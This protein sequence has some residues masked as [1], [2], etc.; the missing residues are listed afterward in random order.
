MARE[1]TFGEHLRNSYAGLLTQDVIEG[2]T[3][4]LT[5]LGLEIEPDV[6]TD[7]P[8]FLDR[9]L[10]TFD[11]VYLGLDDLSCGPWQLEEDGRDK[12]RV[13][14][15]TQKTGRQGVFAG[16]LPYM[17]T[18]SPV[19]QAAEGRFAANSIDRYLQK[20]SL[21]AGREK[22]GPL[23]TRLFTSMTDVVSL[24]VVEAVDPLH[25]YTGEEALQEA[26]R[27]LQCQCLECVK[28]CVYLERFGA[29]PKKYAR[30][31]YNNESIVMGPRQANKL[32]NSCSLCGL[33]QM[34]CPEGFAMQ[35]LCLQ[36]RQG[37][38]MRGKMPPSAHE[39]AL[40]DMAFSQGEQFALARH[41]PGLMESRQA[42]FPGCQLC[43]SA[44]D[45]IPLVYEHLRASLSGGVALSLDAARRLPVGQENRTCL[46]GP[47]E[48]SRDSGVI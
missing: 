10:G 31:I 6:R 39:F 20:V 8:G 21:T 43:G 11:A 19:W 45:K 4:F 9:C 14:P 42:F 27:C 48:K 35:D 34:V 37:M 16:G 25:G 7:E 33:C 44:P 40:L 30:E 2:E 22:E 26:G 46:P 29:Y 12:I 5:K 18:I 23:S 38:V 41:E 36:A 13:E 28:V 17:G 15:R 1:R 24:P 32:I 47:S 3:A